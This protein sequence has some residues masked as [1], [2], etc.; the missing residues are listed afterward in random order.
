MEKK[1]TIFDYLGQV[2]TIFGGTIVILNVFCA[3]F[4]EEAKE[5]STLFVLGNKGLSIST[6]LQFLLVAVII[7]ALRFLLFTDSVIK[8]M[9]MTM[10][11]GIMYLVTIAITVVL[12]MIFGWFPTDM[13]QAWLSFILSFGVCSVVSTVTVLVKD[14]LENDKMQNA[15]ERIKQE[16]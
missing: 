10:R 9:S 8:N 1:K 13:W 4:G 11:T 5:I 14:K 3:I 7:V 12:N 2:L 6:T 16:K 15:L